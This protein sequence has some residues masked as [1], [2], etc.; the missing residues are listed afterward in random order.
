V[1]EIRLLFAYTSSMFHNAAERMCD[2]TVQCKECGENI[3]APV[4]TMPDTWVIAVC[5]LCRSKRRYLPNEIFR[6][7]VSAQLARSDSRPQVH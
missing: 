2:F 1:E 7:R 5:P 6:G 3:P 4:A